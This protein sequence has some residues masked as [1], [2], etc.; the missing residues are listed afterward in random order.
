[1]SEMMSI[2][3]LLFAMSEHQQYEVHQED[4]E[5]YQLQTLCYHVQGLI[6]PHE[7][8]DYLADE[9]AHEGSEVHVRMLIALAVAVLVIMLDDEQQQKSCCQVEYVECVE[10]REGL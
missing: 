9:D 7:D 8:E 1:M 10:T 2:L 5:S 6:K 4:N 3:V